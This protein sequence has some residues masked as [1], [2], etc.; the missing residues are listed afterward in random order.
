M[1]SWPQL[2]GRV[3]GDGYRLTQ[4]LDGSETSGRFEAKSDASGGRDVMVQLFSLT[5][6]Q[7]RERLELWR[8]LQS[9]NRPEI[10]TV[11][12]SGTADWPDL[13][14]DYLVTELPDETLAGGLQN[15]ALDAEEARQVL[16]SVAA[17]LVVMH[18][19]QWVHASVQPANIY[20]VGDSIT[21]SV[22]TVQRPGASDILAEPSEYQAPEVSSFA[23]SPASDIWSLGVTLFQS[24]TQ[25]LPA[26][27]AMER[28]AKLPPPF[29]EILKHS[30]DPVSARRWSAR[31][32][33]QS[34]DTP[35]PEP[36][37]ALD[38]P[39]QP[40]RIDLGRPKGRRVSPF[41]IAAI[42]LFL[43]FL[44]MVFAR[45]KPP[46]HPTVIPSRQEVPVAV[47]PRPAPVTPPPAR[48][49]VPAATGPVNWRVIAFTYSR[50]SD[51]A[52]KAAAINHSHP[53]LHAEVFA[54][55]P[56]RF[57]V[58]LGGWMPVDTAKSLRQQ[59]ISEGM[60][61]DTYAQNF[62]R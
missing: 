60:P 4:Y 15:R 22:A 54:P 40:A 23:F 62:H 46:S 36:T 31:Q 7:G 10:L 6:R 11:L 19:R 20:A 61:P 30:L 59:A 53:D 21:L 25:Q 16:K 24:L 14:F 57:V 55:Q 42:V 27:D 2:Q 5:P 43:A 48:S 29:P 37:P 18:D 34:L 12:S 9:L 28:A 32:I 3:V 26:K 45:K 39:P 52:N 17:A 35:V 51:A 47:P 8:T 38:A 50:Q 13:H 44:W 58:S 49:A 41:A 56:G 33:L 1:L